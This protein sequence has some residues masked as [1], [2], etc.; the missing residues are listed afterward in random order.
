MK[1]FYRLYYRCTA[2]SGSLRIKLQPFNN[3]DTFSYGQ[4][5]YKFPVVTKGTN[6]INA[7]YSRITSTK[8]PSFYMTIY[9]AGLINVTGP[10]LQSRDCSLY[11]NRRM[12][13]S[14]PLWLQ[15][16]NDTYA[17]DFAHSPHFDI[18]PD[19]LRLSALETEDFVQ[20]LLLY[21]IKSPDHINTQYS[22]APNHQSGSKPPLVFAS[23]QV[24]IPPSDNGCRGWALSLF[25]SVSQEN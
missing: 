14:P 6:R 7:M 15:K 2:S 5:V 19:S 8:S 11:M 20:L 25:F 24:H 22:I 16:H 1:R 21:R 10:L 18:S 23:W 9:S 13:A 3:T 12:P 4:L 17:H